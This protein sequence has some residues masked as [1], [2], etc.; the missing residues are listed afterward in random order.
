MWACAFLLNWILN[1]IELTLE[2]NCIELNW[3]ESWRSFSALL[4]TSLRNAHVWIR[5][6]SHNLCIESG[7]HKNIPR[8]KRFSKTCTSTIEDEYHFILVCPVYKELR[9]KFWKKY[10]W[11]KP[12]MFKLISL[13][14][15]D[16]VKELCNLGKYI[17]RAVSLRTNS[18]MWKFNINHYLCHSPYIYLVL[19]TIVPLCEDSP[20]LFFHFSYNFHLNWPGIFFLQSSIMFIWNTCLCYTMYVLSNKE[21]EIELN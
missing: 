2:L 7:R 10:Y 12:S 4:Y 5:V 21:I 1:W 16:N 6:S 8:D 9:S 3:I 18:N 15:V 14:S 20:V 13:L 19:C 17:F 11:G